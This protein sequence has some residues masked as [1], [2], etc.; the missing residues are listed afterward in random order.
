MEHELLDADTLG[1]LRESLERYGREQYGFERRRERLADKAG[2]GRDAWKDYADMGWLAMPLPAD[3]G[4]FDSAPEAIGALMEYVGAALALEPVFA[5]VVLGG[6]LLRLAGTDAARAA[7]QAMAEGKAVVA[8]AHAEDAS[9]GLAGNVQASIVNGRIVGRKQIVLHGDA[10]DYL[11]ASARNGD[12]ELGLYLVDCNEPGVQRS[13]YRLVDGRSAANVR[14]EGPAVTPLA[15]GAQ[16]EAL[17]QQVLDEACLA[18]CS[19]ALGASRALNAQTLAY[20]KDRK[21]FGRPIG[22][23]QALQHR[24]VELYMLEQEGRSVINA[25]FRA[26]AATRRAAIHAALA[27]VMTLGRLASHEAVQLHGGIGITEELAVSH[28][29]RRLMVVN[30]LLGDREQHLQ[31]FASAA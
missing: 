15:A 21:Q 12:G 19:E 2:F 23:N 20:L 17:L 11:V 28:Y 6:R 8:L 9:D 29:F 18:L 31:Q 5:S 22:T 4:G 13:S 30:R 16:A 10:A 3:D 14:F 24:M 1:L 7:L 25:A 26:S 27:Q